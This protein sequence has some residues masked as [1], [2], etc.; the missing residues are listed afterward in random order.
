MLEERE[1][2][3]DGED[4][5]QQKQSRR[6]ERLSYAPDRIRAKEGERPQECDTTHHDKAPV[7]NAQSPTYRKR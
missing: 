1:E 5:N 6:G 7:R 3:E 4:R 2:L